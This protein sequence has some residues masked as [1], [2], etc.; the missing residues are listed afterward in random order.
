MN[1]T[2]CT[3]ARRR[4]EGFTFF[5]L[6]VVITIAGLLMAIALPKMAPLRDGA[7]VNAA[8]QALEGHIAL[9]RQTAV[10]RG[11]T[12]QLL[13]NGDRI[14]VTSTVNAAVDTVGRVI[15]IGDKFGAVLT[16]G[17][18]SLQYNSR[19]FAT[20]AG[21]SEFSLSRNS[22]SATLCVTKLGMVG[23]CGL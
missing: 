20:S 15:D 16:T 1:L 10:R 21:V 4:P 8:K 11:G 22:K 13:V 3:A 5:E 18:T 19:G 12:A 2:R 23:K 14:S 7:G 17:V 6:L 9:A